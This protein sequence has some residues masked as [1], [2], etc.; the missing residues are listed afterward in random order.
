MNTVRNEALKVR[1]HNPKWDDPQYIVPP[2]ETVRK[3]GAYGRTWQ[4]EAFQKC[5]RKPYTFLAAFCGSGKSVVQVALAIDDVI[6]SGYTQKQ[7]VVVPQ[8]HIAG[9]FV[10][11]STADYL[12]IE[13]EGKVYEWHVVHNF[14][15]AGNTQVLAKLKKW[16]LTPAAKLAKQCEDGYITGINAVCSHQALCVLWRQLTDAEKLQAATNLT[17]RVDEAHHIKGVSSVECAEGEE[18]VIANHLGEICRFMIDN[19]AKRARLSLATATPF[20]GDRNMIVSREVA[21]KFETY[22][23]NWNSHFKT[24]GIEH[25]NLLF[26]EYESDPIDAVISQIILDIAAGLK[27][28][29][30][31]VVPPTT[32]KWRRLGNEHLRLMAEL[33]KI[34]P[35]S[36]ICDLVTP[37]TQNKYKKL[38]LQEPK[39]GSEKQPRFSVVVTCMLGREGTDWCPCTRVLNTAVEGSITWAVQT[40]GRV[41]R[42][43]S[44]KKQVMVIYYVP[45][46]ESLSEDISKRELLNDRVTALLICMQLCEMFHPIMMPKIPTSQNER[47]TPSDSTENDYSDAGGY[48]LDEALGLNFQKIK[49]QLLSEIELVRVKNEANVSAVIEEILA[50]Y[51]ADITSR[52]FDVEH[53]KE[54]L[55]VL[56]LRALSPK[57]RDLGIDVRFMRTEYN[58]DTLIEAYNLADK[59][60]FF[61]QYTSTV[62]DVVSSLFARREAK[63]KE[64]EYLNILQRTN[65]LVKAGEEAKKAIDKDYKQVV[66][67]IIVR[68]VGLEVYEYVMQLAPS[69]VRVAG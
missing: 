61:G 20:R 40:L 27:E 62:W 56:V 21:K 36:E 46:F 9:G 44:G 2:N 66:K 26:E 24:L 42:R 64:Q 47:E 39:D 50:V 7:L 11:G 8:S 1:G 33:E 10:Y 13:I 49:H 6:E 29:Y 57:L 31:I 19:E 43:F 67:E 68:E 38:L 69:V 25:F 52:G 35:K 18:V 45:K 12:H 34:F 16:L 63:L 53:V 30:F 22:Y 59:S 14:C 48:S 3:I 60:I 4:L 41:F 28:R 17:I 23:L 51:E 15:D 58:F 65:I 54:G 32:H 55:K 5:R 37:A